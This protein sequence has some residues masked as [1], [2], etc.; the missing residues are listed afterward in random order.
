MTAAQRL[1]LRQCGRHVALFPQRLAQRQ[2]VHQRH[3]HA[4]P[5]LRAHRMRRV[6]EQHA[7]SAVPARQHR[8]AVARAQ[9][10]RAVGYPLQ[11]IAESR[12]QARHFLPPCRHP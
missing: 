12:P 8:I 5:Q 1:V 9:Q 6:A 7:A 2:R 11:A 10:L 3:V 4:L